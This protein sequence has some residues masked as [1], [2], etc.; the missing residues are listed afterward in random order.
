M[1]AR[2]VASIAI[3][4]LA[5]PALAAPDAAA[6]RRLVEEKR[7]ETCHENKTLGIAGAIYL[8]KDHKVTSRPKLEAQVAT[9]N[10]QLNAGLFPEE[11]AQVA[12]YLD[13]TYYKFE[14][15]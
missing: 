9:C 13:T 2:L 6:G 4:A 11:E 3:L 14:A 12:E 7:C 10:A 1:T 15:R 5:A 8:R